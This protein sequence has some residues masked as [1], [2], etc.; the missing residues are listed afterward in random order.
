MKQ[1]YKG[2]YIKLLRPSSLSSLFPCICTEIVIFQFA[3]T[4]STF[5]SSISAFTELFPGKVAESNFRHTWYLDMNEIRNQSAFL[6]N[7]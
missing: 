5:V 2:D 1:G 6:E 3:K 7:W 4:G